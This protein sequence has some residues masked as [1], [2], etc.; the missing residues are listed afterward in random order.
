MTI[1]ATI[2]ENKKKEVAAAGNRVSVAA[3]QDSQQYGRDTFSLKKTLQQGSGIIAEFKRQSPSK[4]II[5]SE[6]KPAETAQEYE[7]FGAAA[8]SVLTDE[9]FFGGTLQDLRA[10][11]AAVKLPLLRKDFMISEY[12]FHE[13][14]ATGADLVLL[15]AAILSPAQTV[16]FA[17]LAKSLNLEVLL[18]IHIED[19]IAHYCPE[20]DFVG[21]NNRNL[22]DFK[23][24]LHHSV[25]L[26][27]ALPEGVLAI[28]ESGISSPEDYRFLKEQNFDGFLMGEYFMKDAAPGK[29]F[30]TFSKEISKP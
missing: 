17:Q 23:V 3:L 27:N 26:R 25:R 18:E 2:V 28:S 16:E 4:G 6:A 11:R 10:V 13:A 22:N 12:Q 19:E 5:N 8:V 29:R 24:D 15:I 20:V 9:R 14:K 30:E 1:L 21:I 7:R